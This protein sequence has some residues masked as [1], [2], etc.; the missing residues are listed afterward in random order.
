MADKQLEPLSAR[1]KILQILKMISE[2]K[3]FSGIVIN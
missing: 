1:R 3:H 2:F